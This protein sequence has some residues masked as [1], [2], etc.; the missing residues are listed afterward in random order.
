MSDQEY[1]L[2]LS[3]TI[4]NWFMAVMVI[5]GGLFG[6]YEYSEYKSTLRVDRALEFV[7]TYQSNDHVVNAR[8]EISATIE[9]RL[10]EI[11]QVLSNP[12]LDAD[13]LA[14]AYHDSIMTI[15]Q[16]DA[17]SI[18][19]EQLFTFYEQVLLCREMELCDETVLL[20]FLDNDAGSYSRTFY[21]YICTVRK[22]W[23]NPEVYSRVV[24]YYMG[25]SEN[26]CAE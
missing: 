23:N 25:G 22:D 26:I 5:V 1:K 14:Q 11:S 10:P 12:G 18:S 9:K 21:P 4:A 7:S 13:Q 16:E 20:N 3:E 8:K 24:T 19:L 6:L 15:V 17:L 2:Q